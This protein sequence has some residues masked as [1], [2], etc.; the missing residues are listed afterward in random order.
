MSELVLYRS[1]DGTVRLDAQ[2][3]RETI[4]LTQKQ[5]RRYHFDGLPREVSTRHRVPYL[6]HQRA[7]AAPCAGLP[8]NE[9]WLKELKQT[10]KLAADISTRKP[11]TG[12]EAALLLQ[13]DS[14]Y[15]TA[16]D[17]L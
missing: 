8:A 10:L 14:E 6:G 13:T 11:L 4:W 9:K 15:A 17:L 7:A 16:L 2:L 1:N 12:D 5:L 3:E